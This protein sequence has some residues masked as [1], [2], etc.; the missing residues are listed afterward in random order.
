MR[1]LDEKQINDKLPVEGA[2]PGS[3]PQNK[4]KKTAY[5]EEELRLIAENRIKITE[6]LNQ[7]IEIINTGLNFF[8]ITAGLN[9]EIV[10]QL[11]FY[12]SENRHI[13]SKKFKDT[14]GIKGLDWYTHERLRTKFK[15]TFDNKIE[16]CYYTN[17]P[18]GAQHIFNLSSKVHN[19]SYRVD[20][21]ISEDQKP[22]MIDIVT[23]NKSNIIKRI[24]IDNDRLRVE[25]E[26]KY[27]KSHENYARRSLCY[28]IPTSS[29][30][31]DDFL[32]S[33]SEGSIGAHHILYVEPSAIKIGY[34]K[35]CS[36]LTLKQSYDISTVIAHHPRNKELILFIMDELD[37][38]LPG[39][40]Q[41][42]SD[43]FPLYKMLTDFDLY[44]PNII[45]DAIIGA[46]TIEECDLNNLKRK[47]EK[48]KIKK[49]NDSKH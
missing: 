44:E 2:V 15:D 28:C 14:A 35:I 4:K 20:I 13:Y 39:I 6:E 24:Q 5:T 12:D 33:M 22:S 16:Y 36:N 38:E 1:K 41:Y 18:V 45:V 17:C 47:K 8:G 42:V 9:A 43:N 27:Y 10:N 29:I 34:E 23:V 3:L 7:Y 40:K 31:S 32:L 49:K 30:D 21:I 48:S 26:K 37:K 46:V 19:S 25:L 11:D